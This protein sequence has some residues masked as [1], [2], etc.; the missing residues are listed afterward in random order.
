M[1]IF[2]IML[3]ASPL[4]AQGDSLPD[5]V[6]AAPEWGNIEIESE[7]SKDSLP[8]NDTLQFT[9]RLRIIGDPDDYSIAEPGNPPVSNLKLIGTSQANRTETKGG[10]IVLIK[11]Y[12]YS[13]MPVTIGMAYINPLRVQ[14]IYIP[15]GASRVLGSGRMEI[16]VTEAIIPKKPV[17][18]LHV[19]IVAVVLLIAAAAVFVIINKKR[20]KGLEVVEVVL[21]PEE[22]AREALRDAKKS[23]G[24]NPDKYIGEMAGILVEYVSKRYAI[25]ARSMSDEQLLT[26]LEMKGVAGTVISHLKNSLIISDQVRFAAHSANP[27]DADMVELGLESLLSYGEHFGDPGKEETSIEG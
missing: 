12:K 13:Y 25:D 3:I 4:F 26:A 20:K 9:V 17:K 2:L 16:E 23:T 7:I 8:Q 11:E 1:L 22:D 19:A 5:S 24:D 21:P 14:Y 27:G 6:I 15:N 10:G 18:L